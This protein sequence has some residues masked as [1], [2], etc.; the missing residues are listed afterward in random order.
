MKKKRNILTSCILKP[1]SVAYGTGM[2]L[3]N[4][5]FDYG[6]L[7]QQE[8]DIPVIV[9]GNLSVGGTGKTPHTEYIIDALR[10]R[11]RLGVLQ[12]RATAARPKDSSM[13]GHRRHRRLTATNLYR[14]T[15]NS[16]KDVSVAVCE[17]R[18]PGNRGDAQD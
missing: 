14:Y 1:L 9:V 16:A 2:K 17:D 13:P 18:C 11:F 3:R 7:K 4:K 6:V 15:E 10:Y 12:R 5:M 8:F